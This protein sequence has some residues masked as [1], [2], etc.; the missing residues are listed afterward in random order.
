MPIVFHCNFC[1]KKIEA[2]DKAAGKWGKCPA[3]H[4][5]LYIPDINADTND[6]KLI[7]LDETEEEKKKQLMTETYKL[8]QDILQEREIPN[9]STEAGKTPAEISNNELTKNI[10]IYLKLMAEG[11]LEEARKIEDVIVPY[12]SRSIQIL[13]RIALSEMPEPELAEI[14]SQVLSGLIR[15]LRSKIG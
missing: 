12:G 6:L 15:G 4:N 7:P 9:E 14:P 2:L 1:N 8:T 5:R 10:I 13:D 3:C 11:E